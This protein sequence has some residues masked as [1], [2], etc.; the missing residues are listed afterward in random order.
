MHLIH[1]TT[2]QIKLAPSLPQFWFHV[3]IEI[4]IPIE[5]V[6]L[7]IQ[8]YFN[9][10]L[11][12]SL[13]SFRDTIR[14]SPLPPLCVL[15]FLLSPFLYLSIS[16]L[17]PSLFANNEREMER[18]RRKWKIDQDMKRT[19][20]HKEWNK[21]SNR[22]KSEGKWMAFPSLLSPLPSLLHSS[23]TLLYIFCAMHALQCSL[24]RG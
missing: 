5:N 15:S 17:I 8:K 16:F 12:L 6:P 22:E 14:L 1:R 18:E 7:A 11:H 21:T 24:R 3:P 13:P 19:Q 20:T 4:A 10:W 23:F 2:S 9:T